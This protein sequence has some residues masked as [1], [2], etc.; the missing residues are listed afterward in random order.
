MRFIVVDVETRDPY[1]NK[2]I[3]LG[4]GYV[5]QLHVKTALSRCIGFSFCYIENNQVSKSTYLATT[6]QNI[7]LLKDL[8]KKDKNIVCHNAQYDLGYLLTLGIPIDDLKVYDTKIIAQLYDNTLMSYSLDPLS[9]LYLPQESQKEKFNLV[10]IVERHNLIK[11]N[12]KCK[13]YTQAATKFAYENMDVLQDLDFDTM[14]RYANQDTVAT[15]HL[16]I[17]FLTRVSL[18]DAQYWS[19]FQLICTR[20]RVKGL[21]VSM[22]AINHGIDLMTPIEKELQD[23]V[24]ALAGKEFNINSPKQLIEIMNVKSTA[25]EVL[26]EMDTPL[27]KAVLEFR[28]VNKILRDFLINIRDMQIYTCPEAA[29]GGAIGRVFPQMDVFG[30]VTG[31]FSSSK[32]NIQQIPK[33]SKQYGNLCRSMFIP[34][35]SDNCWYSLDWSNQEGRLAVHYA[36]L[37]GA[38]GAQQVAADWRLSP[39]LDLH[40]KVADMVRC[41]R[42]AAKTINLGLIYSLG[43]A[44]LC[45]KLGLPTKWVETDYG[46]REVAGDE[47][48]DLLKRYHTANPWLKALN[49]R[50]KKAIAEQG[51]IKTIGNR[52][53]RREEPRFDYKALNKIIQGSAADQMLWALRQA[54]DAG[55]D[56]KCIVHDEFNVEGEESATK[57]KEIMEST[58]CYGVELQVPMLAEIKVGTSW[59]ELEEYKPC[60]SK[61][62]VK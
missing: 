53:V 3:D 13:T 37:I 44:N 62:N 45:K 19:H 30:A 22:S 20:N 51:G 16:L 31:R 59:G 42:S 1:L 18:A 61:K 25:K 47:G 49:E 32:P 17:K 28:E 43:Q 7:A 54:D 5:Y 33:R 52:F 48:Q 6:E 35:C 56:I 38:K 15:A 14:A 26:E 24:W 60:E 2:T 10:S 58:S 27:A 39:G 34:D 55:V 40:Q 36:S 9:K 11:M 57:M 46:P 29:A 41:D 23:K 50:A 21:A 4:P 8:L 12:P